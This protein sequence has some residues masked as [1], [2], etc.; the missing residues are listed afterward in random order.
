MEMFKQEAE[1]AMVYKYEEVNQ[2][3]SI[4]NGTG[5]VTILSDHFSLPPLVFLVAL[6]LR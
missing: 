5:D 2:M 3:I 6:C 4:K 1:G